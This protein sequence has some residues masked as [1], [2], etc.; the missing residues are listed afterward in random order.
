MSH[1]LGSHDEIAGV[2]KT[3]THVG[4]L[5]SHPSAC[6]RHGC[7][8]EM[9]SLSCHTCQSQVPLSVSHIP[10]PSFLATLCF[11][12]TCYNALF[13]FYLLQCFVLSLLAPVFCS[14]ACYKYNTVFFFCLLQYIVL[15]STV[16][17]ASSTCYSALFFLCLLQ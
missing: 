9:L 16:L 10:L 6:G 2:L 12:S 5:P 14:S 13:C 3:A 1:L 15:L 11:S 4:C 7:V 17:C 8:E